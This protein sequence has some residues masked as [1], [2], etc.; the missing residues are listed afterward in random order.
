MTKNLMAKEF[1]TTTAAA[2]VPILLALLLGSGCGNKQPDNPNTIRQ[3]AADATAEV[4]KD[5]AAIVQ[6]VKEGWNRD[7]KNLVDLNS[8]TKP[9]LMQLPGINQAT[10]DVLIGGRPYTTAHDVVTKKIL[11]EAEYT[12]IADK[13]TV[14]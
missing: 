14:N 6:G 8:A 12:K 13:V 1:V 10:A 9:Q 11:S 7:K 3:R 4:K 2:F 5:S